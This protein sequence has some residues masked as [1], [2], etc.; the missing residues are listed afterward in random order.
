M[1]TSRSRS[2]DGEKV[3]ER[4]TVDR[5]RAERS[6][7][8]TVVSLRVFLAG[9]VLTLLQ[10]IPLSRG[11]PPALIAPLF[12]AGFAVSFISFLAAF[13]GFLLIQRIISEDARKRGGYQIQG[14]GRFF[15][16]FLSDL[17]RGVRT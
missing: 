10:I 9:L 4:S 5:I 11:A 12:F 7:R 3:M 15:K 13:P 8:F 16:L 6:Y 14:Q 17:F 2:S 1:V